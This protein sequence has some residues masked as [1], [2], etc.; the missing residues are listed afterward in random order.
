[1]EGVD[2]LIDMKRR[3]IERQS[4][5]NKLKNNKIFGKESEINVSKN[6][7]KKPVPVTVSSMA[8]ARKG[9]ISSSQHHSEKPVFLGEF[10]R[11]EDVST[12]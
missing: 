2:K 11:S 9:N 4:E 7:T 8:R 3:Q 6:A 12:I 1:M 10:D 5:I